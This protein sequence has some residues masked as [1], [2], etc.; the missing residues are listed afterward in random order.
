MKKTVDFLVNL[1]KWIGAASIAVM[2]FLTCL[3]VILRALNRPLAGAVEITGFLATIGLACSLPYTHVN[4]GHVGVDMLVRHLPSKGQGLVDLVTGTLAL[5]L[6]AIISWRCFV[7]GVTLQ[8]S[9]E[10]S[11]TLGWP[12]YIFVHLIGFAFAVLV[13]TI[14][15]DV[16]N[17]WKKVIGK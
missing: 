14:T 8:Q 15:T 5:G 13:L 6:F 17:A 2:M 16:I 12:S 4:H 11:M 10:V 1:L 7:Y 3:D 9:G